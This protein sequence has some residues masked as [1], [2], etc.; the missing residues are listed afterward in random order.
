MR[1]TQSVFSAAV[2]ASTL[3]LASIAGA[4]MASA[5]DNDAIT[6]NV[7]AVGDQTFGMGAAFWC[8]DEDAKNYNPNSSTNACNFSTANDRLK[9][10]FQ[11]SISA[12]LFTSSSNP[13]TFSV[14]DG[15]SVG[16]TP[17]NPS[18]APVTSVQ[19]N[20]GDNL[21]VTAVKGAGQC[22]MTG[23]TQGDGTNVAGASYTYTIALT[24]ADQQLSSSLPTNTRMR[25]G[26]RLPL[27]GAGGNTTNAGQELAW[28]VMRNSRGN[29]RLIERP[30]GAI[31]L[32]ATS[33]GTC[34][35]QVRAPGVA[36]E[37]NKFAQQINIRVR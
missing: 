13:A 21:Y 2:A 5:Q 3:T 35:V 37:W 16:T 14:T 29:C 10:P 12:T 32:R 31:N 11:E 9:L 4:Q 30:N 15:C 19:V 25:V 24:P 17:S 26:Q 7:M 27:Q 18:N 28:R 36:G 20:A 6:L 1:K 34:R 22:T 33:R 23:T 8:N